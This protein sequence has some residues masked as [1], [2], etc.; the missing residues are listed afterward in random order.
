MHALFRADAS[1]DIGGGHV[2]RCLTLADTLAAA[3]WSCGFAFRSGTLQT[4]PALKRSGHVLQLLSGAV[5]D[6]PAEMA[7]TLRGCCDLLVVDHYGRGADFETA[8]RSFAHRLLVFDDQP[9]RRHD[10]DLLLDATPR[11]GDNHY[12]GLVPPGCSLLLGPAFVPLRP[13]FALARA[14]AL[15]RRVRG[16]A[17]QRLL[18]S[19]GLTDRLNVTSRILRGVC[20]SGLPLTVDVVLGSAAPHLESV[21]GLIAELKLDAQLH[22]DVSDMAALAAAADLAIGAGGQSSLERCCLGLP[23]LL[24]VT[25]DNQRDLAAGLERCGAA[26]LLSGPLIE[27]DEV[28]RALARIC[29]D[30]DRRVC[31]AHAAAELCDGRGPVRVQI[32]LAGEERAKGGKSVRLRLATQADRDL[33]LSW[34]QHP[35]TRRFSHNPQAPTGAEHDRWLAGVLGDP[36]RLLMISLC[37]EKPAGML[38]LDRIG[39]NSQRISIL[40]A[41]EFA[42]SGVAQACLAIARRIFPAAELCAEVLPEN[43]ASRRLFQSAGYIETEPGFFTRSE[44]PNRRHP[45]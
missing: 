3:G 33:L 43:E 2:M 20:A 44:E 9:L 19:V 30:P 5:A 34:Q 45:S 1:P 18:V 7:E 42:R 11:A 40:T 39:P 25:A 24:V 6:E 17:V 15:A 36:S 29:A 37:D 14:K 21:R 22:V 32:A 28:A 4:V 12:R 8:C 23:S 27:P 38:R 41:P 13:E 35:A 26:A 10:A 16:G 31:M